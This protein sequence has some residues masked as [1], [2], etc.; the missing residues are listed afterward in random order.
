MSHLHV[1]S[2]D[3]HHTFCFQFLLPNTSVTAND[4]LPSALWSFLLMTYVPWVSI[5]FFV[6]Q[7]LLCYI[8]RHS[9]VYKLP[10]NGIRYMIWHHICPF[11]NL[12][13]LRSVGQYTRRYNF[14]HFFFFFTFSDIKRRT[15]IE[16]VWKQDAEE[17]LC[18]Y[19]TGRHKRMDK[20]A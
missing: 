7:F 4:T 19:E 15:Q 10:V 20:I 6:L 13:T 9:T 2:D 1:I 14:W 18:T 17:S 11:Y 12:S 5:T 3:R 8:Y 16:G